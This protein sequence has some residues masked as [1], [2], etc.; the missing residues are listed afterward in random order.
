MLYEY[1]FDDIYI[2]HAIDERPDDTEY[3]MHIH[4]DCE[5]YF[6]VSGDVEYLVEDSR[7]PLRGESLMLMRPAEI[8]KPKLSDSR[9]YER[10]TVNFPTSFVRRIDP[11]G[12]LLSAFLNRPLGKN[13]CYA[14]DELDTALVRTL[15]EEMCAP[16]K[17]DYEKRLTATTHI[18]ML[19][20]L[21]NRAFS[22]KKSDDFR[23]KSLAETI[24]LYLESHL[25]D[26]LSVPMLA[27]QF[28]LSTS[29]FSRIFKQATGAAPWEY[30]TKKRLI[31]ANEKIRGGTTAQKACEACGFS[32]YSAFYR[33]Y[34][35]HFGCSP[36]NTGK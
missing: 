1:F 8:H 32:D 34:T 18:Y 6:F 10:F 16:S 27:A 15:F 3:T 7:Y 35:K 11:D 36:A 33:A 13:N 30:I 2:K 23:P 4:G 31:A 24:I 21:I 28:H 9:S 12:V 25:F 19:L 17:S 22:N 26:E 29:Q 14:S 5:I 20:D